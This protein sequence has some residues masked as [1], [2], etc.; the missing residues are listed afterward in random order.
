MLTIAFGLVFQCIPP[1]LTFMISSLGLS[2]AQAG[3]LMSLFALPGVFVSIPGGIIANAYGAKRVFIGALSVVIFGSTL[4][5]LASGFPLLIVG[6]IIAGIGA[7]TIAVAAPQTLSIWFADRGLSI[8]FGV[9]NNALPL[10]IMVTFNTYGSLAKSTSWQIP[11]WV[12]VAYCVF[13]LLLLIWKF[14][15]TSDVEQ[16]RHKPAIKESLI[17]LTKAGWPVWLLSLVWMVYNT[18]S[19]SFMT[20]AGDHYIAQ[21]YSVELAGFMTSLFMMSSIVLGPILGIVID[22]IGKHIA[23]I[24]FGCTSLAVLIFLVPRSSMDPLLLVGLIG[25]CSVF[26][27]T[28]LLSLLPRY[29]PGRHSGLGYGLSSALANLG[30][31]IGPYLVGLI[32]DKL[33][34]HG[35]GFDLMAFFSIVG[36]VLTL[37]VPLAVRKRKRREENVI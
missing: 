14:P 7:M 23:F 8:A 6:R 24:V 13:V 33:Q 15:A 4:V 17:V 28:P 1:I 32:Y 19:I 11:M 5:A 18:A 3:A 30:V 9:Y 20:F 27:P 31:L 26:I 34:H 10:A 36:T 22:R 37:M 21:G 25:L 29:L 16:E 2:H 35:R 12:T